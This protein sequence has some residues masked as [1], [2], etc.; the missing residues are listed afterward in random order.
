MAI[1]KLDLD[2]F[3]EIDYHLIMDNKPNVYLYD[4]ECLKSG[5][6]LFGKWYDY[7]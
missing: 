4:D 1:H 7:I 3:D 5:N 6:A 2:E